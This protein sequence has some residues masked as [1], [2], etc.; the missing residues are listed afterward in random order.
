MKR[1]SEVLLFC[2]ALTLALAPFAQAQESGIC[3]A[4]V[5][6]YID[7]NEVAYDAV[8]SSGLFRRCRRDVND[9]LDLLKDSGGLDL[10][11]SAHMVN[12]AAQGKPID[13]IGLIDAYASH[14]LVSPYEVSNGAFQDMVEDILAHL[15]IFRPDQ[16]GDDTVDAP[17]CNGLMV[18]SRVYTA[19]HCLLMEEPLSG[20]ESIPFAGMTCN[21]KPL[22]F[23]NFNIYR[24]VD[25]KPEEVVVAPQAGQTFTG[26]DGYVGN[27]DKICKTPEGPLFA[28]KR[29]A[30]F[31]NDW[32]GLSVAPVEAKPDG[33][34]NQLDFH[35]KFHPKMIEY[36]LVSS[37]KF[38][39]ALS[40]SKNREITFEKLAAET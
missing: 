37:N 24:I 23:D 4:A 11:L 32:V 1:P 29:S 39:T 2:T 13:G 26:P 17:F 20:T 34:M 33:Y 14:C 12:D 3:K 21:A 6:S 22:Q 7:E 28:E 8:Y 31:A 35:R 5:N 25:K 36:M 38:L 9:L 27:Q 16:P 10:G 30:I 19:R 40:F 15:I 18:G